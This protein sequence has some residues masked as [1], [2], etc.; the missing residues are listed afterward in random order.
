[1]LH[2]PRSPAGFTLV[3]LMTVILVIGIVSGIV[4]SAA[5]YAN[6]MALKSRT[7]ATIH[8]VA[9]AVDMFYADRG[10]YPPDFTCYNEGSYWSPPNTVYGS[11]T[12]AQTVWPCEALWFWL[13]YNNPHYGPAGYQKAPYLVFKRE[14]VS[15]GNTK[16]TAQYDQAAGNYMR[17]VDAWG[18]P[19]NYKSNNGNFSYKF[20]TKFVISDPANSEGMYLPR[21]NRMTFDLCSYGSDG[22]TWQDRDKPFNRQQDLPLDQM[23]AVTDNY[24]HGGQIPNFFYKAFDTV[25]N[26]SS[27]AKHCYGGED[28][29]DINNWHL[30]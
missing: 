27:G 12:G 11:I 9:G 28:N 30:R 23:R 26:V 15:S 2:A 6:K 5:G 17:I 21:H 22:T 14:Q 7:M 19:L 20:T 4:I 8:Q 1:M 16:I 18:N 24:S 13:E 3:E 10:S 29:D 25:V